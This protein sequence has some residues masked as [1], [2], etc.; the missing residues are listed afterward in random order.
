VAL[1]DTVTLT[2]ADHL[3][4]AC[5]P[6]L[7]I[8]AQDNLAYRAAASFSTAYDVDVL[9]DIH[10][11]KRIPSGAGLGGGS[12]DAAAVLVGLAHWAGLP[13]DERRL[14]LIARALGADVPFFLR[15]GAALM[16][17]RG[18]EFVR[19][20]PALTFPVALVK[21]PTPVGTADAY[22]AFDAAPQAVGEVRGVADALRF[23]DVSALAASVANNMTPASASL[24]PQIA[25]ARAW[26][27]GEP[28][29]LGAQMAGSGSAVFAIC[30]SDADCERIA[31]AARDRGWWGAATRGSAD[32]AVVTEA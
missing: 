11:T 8:R 25:E 2:P 19:S 6:D 10:V 1:A 13:L 12:S 26:L 15:G 28:G 20:L 29:V 9:L 30:A 23:R 24:V 4:V 16:A 7:A 21:P 22:R 14:V 3:T 17:G 31:S 32:G 27:L 18:D 5:T